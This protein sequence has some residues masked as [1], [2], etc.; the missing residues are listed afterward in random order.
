MT[1]KEV[2][3]FQDSSGVSQVG[4]LKW[5][6]SYNFTNEE[7]IDSYQF[8]VHYGSSEHSEEDKV[9][10]VMFSSFS[11]ACHKS[12]K[13]H[14]NT[15]CSKIPDKVLLQLE[16]VAQTVQN[17]DPADI[18]EDIRAIETKI[19]L[20][21]IELS[22][23]RKLRTSIRLNIAKTKAK[24]MAATSDKDRVFYEGDL[25]N[26]HLYLEQV[27]AKNEESETALDDLTVALKEAKIRQSKA[28]V[29]R[30]YISAGNSPL[31]KVAHI[32]SSD[33]R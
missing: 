13:A 10:R 31:R 11:S 2:F 24:L 7:E 27:R 18:E 22:T 26:F 9:G 20:C 1:E 4:F 30:T 23:G 14:L 6:Q 3:N 5:I 32:E 8:L 33:S 19:E 25:K 12:I 28:P 21:E 15:H 17:Q 29:K 16:G